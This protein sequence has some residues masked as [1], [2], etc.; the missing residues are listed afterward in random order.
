MKSQGGGHEA[1]SFRDLA[2]G[3][4]LRAALNQLSVDRQAMLVRQGTQRVD[5]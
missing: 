4:A 3:Q 2:G 1:D 5:D